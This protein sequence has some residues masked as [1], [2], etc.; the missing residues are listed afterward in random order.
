MIKL[1]DRDA[2]TGCS[3]C[4]AACPQQCIELL[5]D[6]DGFWYPSVVR[7]DLCVNCQQCAR[8]C[9]VLSRETPAEQAVQAYAAYS[10]DRAVRL[11]SSSGGV[12]SELAMEILNQGGIVYGAAYDEAF[13][14]CHMGISSAE[15]L[16]R[17]RGA[18]YAQSSLGNTFTEIRDRLR[19]G[20]AVLFSGTPCQA[21]GLKS[22]LGREDENLLC[23]DFVCHG[24]PAPGAWEAYLQNRCSEDNQGT[25]PE[26]VNLR[27]KES[28][29]SRYQY[30]NRIQYQDG[31]FFS[32]PS[33]ENLY[34]KLF[35]GNYIL[36][37]SC[38]QC[39]FKGYSRVSDI[40]LGDF[41]GIWDIAPD[42]DDNGG[43]SLVLLH[44]E[45]GNRMFEQVRGRLK[46][47]KVTLEEAGRQNPSLL[48]A[49]AEKPQRE[50]V[51]RMIREGR[52]EETASL[53]PSQRE[54][55]VWNRVRQAVK[56]LVR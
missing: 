54:H 18:K 47:R 42:M 9:P 1:A 49:S 32:E 3:A 34:M 7:P 50:A 26:S 29:W 56:R 43:T 5:P 25:L 19:K 35:V 41:W 10:L 30:S 51:L 21:A 8:A 52:I 12:F 39:R 14:V 17:L 2:C 13:R 22:F 44:S 16:Q 24:V 46:T 23:V 48:R 36:R 27:S 45:R 40:T 4:A 33:G 15:D 6:Q 28:G 31:R 20:Q 53:F 38:G 37:R 55:P 11:A